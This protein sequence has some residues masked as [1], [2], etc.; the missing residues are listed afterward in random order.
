M[1]NML[2]VKVNGRINF[3]PFRRCGLVDGHAT[4]DS[5]FEVCY[6]KAWVEVEFTSQVIRVYGCPGNKEFVFKIKEDIKC[7]TL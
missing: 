5:G 1:S 4:K 2:P 6:K 3:Y 7:Q